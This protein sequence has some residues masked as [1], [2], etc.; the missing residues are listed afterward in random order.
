[1]LVGVLGINHKSASLEERERQARLFSLNQQAGRVVLSTCNRTEIYFGQEMP[2]VAMEPTFYTF[3][4]V[5]CFYHLACVAAGLDSALLAES[6]IKGQVAAAYE[7]ARQQGPLTPHLHYLFQKALK[8]AKDARSRFSLFQSKHHLEALIFKLIDS[9]LG[10][11]PSLLFIGFS[12]VNRTII[13][14]LSQI[15]KYRMTLI[16][17][18]L[19]VARPFAL[20]YGLT[21]KNRDELTCAHFYEGII[22]ATR[23]ESYLLSSFPSSS[24]TRLILD[25]SIPRTIDPKLAENP[26]LTLLNMQQMGELFA[27]MHSAHH[28]E[29]TKVKNF[30]DASVRA[31]AERFERKSLL[32]TASV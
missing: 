29:G 12:E 31:Y 17:R 28:R 14:Y 9:F 15:K 22:A 3:S 32:Y 1:M 6:A 25:L 11:S 18:D 26:L 27:K 10:E 2:L 13:H 8:I 19:E 30:I 24:C 23:A 7:T 20:R 5:E 4:G 21:L 16:S